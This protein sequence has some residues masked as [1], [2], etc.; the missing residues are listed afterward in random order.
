[1]I[2]LLILSHLVVAPLLRTLAERAKRQLHD[3]CG[4]FCVIARFAMGGAVEHIVPAMG[5]E[6][7]TALDGAT[8]YP[9]TAA[10]APLPDAV[11]AVDQHLLRPTVDLELNG[12]LGAR[13]HG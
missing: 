4:F 9:D 13:L 11:H 2:G 12:V 7:I 3:C 1:M 5:F 6:A 10:P 8:G